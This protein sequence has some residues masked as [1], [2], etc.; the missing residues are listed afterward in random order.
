MRKIGSAL[1]VPLVSNQLHGGRTPILGQDQL[2]AIGYR[3]AIYPT[4]GLLAVAHALDSVYNSL[5]NKEPVQVPL[6]DFG[7][8]NSLID[9]ED[10][11]DFEKKYAALEAD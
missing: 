6:Y 11:W 10:V 3:M 4:A 1:D 5:V 7:A 9:F 2:R 8:F